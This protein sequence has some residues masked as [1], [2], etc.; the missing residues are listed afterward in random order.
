MAALSPHPPGAARG[1]EGLSSPKLGL[2]GAP[3]V[4]LG[5]LAGS[6]Q[7]RV[8]PRK[9]PERDPSP[10][11]AAFIPIPVYWWRH[12]QSGRLDPGLNPP[13]A[14]ISATIKVV[15]TVTA[16][17]SSG[18]TVAKRAFCDINERLHKRLFALQVKQMSGRHG[19]VPPFP[20]APK[21]IVP[22]LFVHFITIP[23]FYLPV[24]T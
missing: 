13:T 12:T 17:T 10:A 4:P 6:T 8:Q 9:A 7:L 21:K 14:L 11:P 20:P 5:L 1:P 22:Y 3:C 15:S 18:S 23:A 16:P 19:N 24:V 2:T